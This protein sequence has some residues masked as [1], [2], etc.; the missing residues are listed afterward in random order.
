M[1]PKNQPFKKAAM[2]LTVAAVLFTLIYVGAGFRQLELNTGQ[3]NLEETEVITAESHQLEVPERLDPYGFSLETMVYEEG[4]VKRNE[5]FYVI[6]RRHGLTPLEIRR[7]SQ[8]ARGVVNLKRLLPGQK[9][10]IYY[11]EEMPV[12]FV[13][14]QSPLQYVRFDWQSETMVQRGT[15]P[16]TKVEAVA[17]DV[18]TSSLYES[19]MSRS[20]TAE[21]VNELADLFAWQVNFFG[22]QKGD[23]FKV[24]YDELYANGAFIGIGDIRFAEFQ[25]KGEIYRA[26]LYNHPDRTGYFD[27]QGNS[28]QKEL[29]KAPFKYSQRISSGFSHS[30]FHPVLKKRRP[31][32]GT[33]YAAPTGTPVLAVGDGV[34]TEAQFRGGNGNIVQIRH[35]STYR[36]AYLHLN[37]FARGIKKG[38][39]VQQGD[40]IGYVGQTGLSTGPH[41]CYRLYKHD[42][43]VNSRNIDLPASESLE[44]IYLSDFSLIVDEGNKRLQETP[45]QTELASTE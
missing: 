25:H 24:L 37:G 16:V 7:L 21:L 14:Q 23:H 17:G 45:L 44:E 43:P 1:I 27:E 3:Q 5:S 15:F 10:R 4:T 41:L 2:G 34:V 28:L 22:L 36:T 13:W 6:L 30:R 42:Q 31:H 9:Y 40:V 39:K 26:Y 19:M 18:I 8:Q 35:N 38:V 33:D 12:S 32:Y 29:L 11:Q 20:G